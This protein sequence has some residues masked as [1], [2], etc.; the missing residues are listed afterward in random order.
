VFGDWFGLKKQDL[1]TG[2]DQKA[3]TLTDPATLE[4]FGALPTVSGVSVT[5][6]TALRVPAVLQAV[7]LIAETPET[8]GS[9]PKSSKVAG[10]VSVSAF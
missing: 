7:R 9:A 5:V 3:L 6:H 8:V 2:P 10:S 1:N 4:L